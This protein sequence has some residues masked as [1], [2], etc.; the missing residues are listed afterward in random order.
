M[1]IGGVTTTTSR[2]EMSPTWK[3][4]YPSTTLPRMKSS[5]SNIGNALRGSTLSRRFTKAPRRSPRTAPSAIMN[6]VIF[7]KDLANWRWLIIRAIDVV[8]TVFADPEEGMRGRDFDS[9]LLLQDA[10]SHLSLRGLSK[11]Q[12]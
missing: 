3:K 9:V 7:L 10:V 2:I 1:C 12:N 5:W 8:D 6:P 11:S 4:A